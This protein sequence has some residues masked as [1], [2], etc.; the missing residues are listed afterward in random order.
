VT[1]AA[2]GPRALYLLVSAAVFALDQWTKWLVETAIPLHGARGVVPG[3]FEISHV[4][5]TG[6]AFGLM[7]AHGDWIATWL[8]AAFG[9]GALA[10]VGWFFL[11]TPLHHRR[12]LWALALVLGG[13]L[14][15]LHDRLTTGAVTDFLGFFHGTYRFPDFNL[16]DSAITIGIGLVLL[17]AILQPAAPDRAAAGS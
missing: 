7:Q 11:R 2:L 15:N 9:L 4:R 10:L 14:G 8:L 17:D 1:R 12:L 16:A 6:V 3:L 5:N 13:A